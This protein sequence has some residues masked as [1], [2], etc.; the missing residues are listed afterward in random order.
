MAEPLT[1]YC[2]TERHTSAFTL[3]AATKHTV[4]GA[5]Y[6][7]AVAVAVALA[8]AVTVTVAVAIHVARL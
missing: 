7:K 8:L 3:F 1:G 5:W 2:D 6:S 4:H